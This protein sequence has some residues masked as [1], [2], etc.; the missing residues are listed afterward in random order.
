MVDNGWKP[1]CGHTELDGVT[2]RIECETRGGKI[3]DYHLKE[4][5]KLYKEKRWIT[6]ETKKDGN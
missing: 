1:F 3:E 2:Y 6:A 5:V 4:I